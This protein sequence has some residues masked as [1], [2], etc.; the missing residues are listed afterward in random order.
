MSLQNRGYFLMHGVVLQI[1]VFR[2][3]ARHGPRETARDVSRE[4][5]LRKTA[6]RFSLC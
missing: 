6:A 4:T 1:R 3:G 2:A 5:F